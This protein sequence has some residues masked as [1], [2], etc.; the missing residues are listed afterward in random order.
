MR[1]GGAIPLALT[2]RADGPLHGPIPVVNLKEGP[3]LSAVMARRAA[4]R[5]WQ[6]GLLR[7][8]GREARSAARC[9]TVAQGSSLL[10]PGVGAVRS[11]RE[12]F[13]AT[14]PGVLKSVR[15]RR[16]TTTSS[17]SEK[18][19]SRACRAKGPR[20]VQQQRHRTPARSALMGLNAQRCG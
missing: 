10:L 9:Y 16:S 12:P 20:P 5:P 17:R 18:R 6:G 4:P 15:A 3:A 14:Y 2:P 1:Y 19:T 8:H 13:L 7:G 11:R